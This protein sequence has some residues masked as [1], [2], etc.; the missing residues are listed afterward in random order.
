[1]TGA[2]MRAE[3]AGVNRKS[4]DS[5]VRRAVEGKPFLAKRF[6]V[7]DLLNKL[8]GV[9]RGDID[10][11]S[12]VQAAAAEVDRDA[13]NLLSRMIYAA[14]VD[15]DFVRQQ[16]PSPVVTTQPV[17]GSDGTAL[18]RFNQM[19]LAIE[20]DAPARMASL[21]RNELIRDCTRVVGEFVRR[22]DVA[23]VLGRQEAARF[24][25]GREGNVHWSVLPFLFEYILKLAAS[26]REAG[27]ATEA[28]QCEAWVAN[29]EAG[30]VRNESD[31]PTRLLCADLWADTTARSDPANAARVHQ[32]RG[33]FRA[34]A[35]AA[36]VDLCGQGFVHARSV[37]PREYRWAFVLLIA[38]VTAGVVG[39]GAGLT[40]V[41]SLIV[42]PVAVIRARMNRNCMRPVDL[43]EEGF[44]PP[45]GW[46]S[47]A[48][49][50]GLVGLFAIVFSLRFQVDQFV[51]E[52]GMIFVALL[53]LGTG[54]AMSVL[55]AAL[56]ERSRPAMR[57][58]SA[59]AAALFFTAAALPI[60]MHAWSGRF[61]GL[62]LGAELFV[63]P[64]IAGIVAT[65]A[66]L[67]GAK[68][69]SVAWSSAVVW[70]VAMGLA[71]LVYQF[72]AA[73]DRRYQTAA[74]AGYEDEVSARL[75]SGWEAK[76]FG[77]ALE[78]YD[79]MLNAKSK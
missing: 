21:H 67:S 14:I 44:R 60:S 27:H 62:R 53:V 2:M 48:V 57:L 5:A 15:I 47:S 50:V 19:R 56:F 49:A 64:L 25:Y 29:C 38:A 76:Y 4:L 9:R 8:D 40:L 6:A 46:Q 3:A 45:S 52:A 12:V 41:V 54:G 17:E 10:A 37:A 33:D 63:F 32:F 69:R 51:S 23:A 75:G 22:P 72:H 71:V 65:S 26:L 13:E 35:S 73:A 79:L 61:F 58:A 18:Q 16:G 20:H 66:V 39:A 70:V 68:L 1:M 42:L 78:R 11:A 24:R 77:E 34:A 7:S 74:A 30:L 28:A 55:L 43:T 31:A 36:P 59:G